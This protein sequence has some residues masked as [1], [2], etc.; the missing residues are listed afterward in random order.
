MSGPGQQ[1]HHHQ[2]ARAVP[3]SEPKAGVRE[4][5][6]RKCFPSQVRRRPRLQ[7]S[8]PC[9]LPFVT[10]AFSVLSVILLPQALRANPRTGVCDTCRPP[11]PASPSP[12]PAVGSYVKLIQLVAMV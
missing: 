9:T 10:R 4:R 5:S 8:A 11:G 12:P 2:G 6:G 1:G 3:A 7:C